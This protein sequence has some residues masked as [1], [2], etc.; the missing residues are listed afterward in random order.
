MSEVSVF[1]WSAFCHSRDLHHK[2]PDGGLTR[3]G[4]FRLLRNGLCTEKQFDD[5]NFFR[6]ELLDV[7]DV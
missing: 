2:E 1:S 5:D 4:F 3:N 7:D 6:L